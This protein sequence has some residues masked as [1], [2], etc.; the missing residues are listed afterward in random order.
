MKKINYEIINIDGFSIIHL[1]DS[2]RLESKVIFDR[3]DINQKLI[4]TLMNISHKYGVGCSAPK[5]SNNFEMIF[6]IGADASTK[7][8]LQKNSNNLVNC[9]KEVKLFSEE[10]NKQLDF[11]NL[12]L[13]MFNEEDLYE[14][15]P[16]HLAAV[17]D[18]HF[19][20]SWAKFKRTLK[21][22]G[23]MYE[24]K[25]ID[26]CKKFEKI[27]EK[28]LGLIGHKLSE[29]IEELGVAENKILN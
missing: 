7:N 17:R 11:S 2:K 3:N 15:S 23:K 6:Y 8:Q 10:F 1:S 9:L 19:G 20:G 22:E 16:E 24:S 28:D 5:F 12:D 14:F 21:K 4:F 29:I 27:N 18:Q 13:T 25:I 26:K